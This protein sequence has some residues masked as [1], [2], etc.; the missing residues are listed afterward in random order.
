M[1]ERFFNNHPAPVA[2]LFD[3]QAGFGYPFDD[4]AEKVGRG[5]KV[6]KVVAMGVV[7]LVHL[8]ERFF[9]LVVSSGIIEISTD[10]IHAAD[11]GVPEFSVDGAGGELLEVLAEFFSRVVMAHGSAADADDGEVG[12]EQLLAQE[13]V[14]GGN[15]LASRQVAGKAKDRHDARIRLACRA[16]FG[17]CWQNFCMSHCLLVRVSCG[18][19]LRAW[20]ISDICLPAVRSSKLFL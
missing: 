10:V 8:G 3:H 17:C 16:R 9:Q 19:R 18:L 5:S 7:I 4:I 20:A 12:R 15:K 11:E 1:A 13:V 2:V 14:E 6:K